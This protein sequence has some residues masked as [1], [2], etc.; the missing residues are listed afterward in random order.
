MIDVGTG[1]PEKHCRAL[2]GRPDEGVWAHVGIQD[3][4]FSTAIEISS[5]KGTYRSQPRLL[6][7]DQVSDFLYEI[8]REHVFGLLFASGADV[9]FASF[10]FFVSDN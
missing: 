4:S 8:R 7:G 10:G 5:G 3:R 9:D 2:P 6:F 1:N